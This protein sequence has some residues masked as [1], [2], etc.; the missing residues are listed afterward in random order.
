MSAVISA[1]SAA[2]A[3]AGWLQGSLNPA[4][5]AVI[6]H[7]D[8]AETVA[9]MVLVPSEFDSRVKAAVV[10][11]GQIPTWGEQRAV[12]LPT[13]VEQGSADTINMPFHSRDLY[14]RLPRPKAYLDVL[15]GTHIGPVIGTSRQAQDLRAVVIAFLDRELHG[16]AA[17]QHQM[18]VFGN[19]PSL[20]A[21]DD[22]L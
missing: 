14:R 20:T 9:G 6:G 2:A 13:L 4:E 15:E 12:R 10:L 8:G 19:Q 1:I 22:E 21:L 11:A 3:P 5:V 18:D 16:D 7:S 17:A